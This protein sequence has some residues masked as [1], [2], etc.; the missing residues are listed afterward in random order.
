VTKDVQPRMLVVGNPAKVL[1]E[2]APEELLAK[3][4]LVG[5]A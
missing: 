1:R 3:S 4:P 2:V 5:D